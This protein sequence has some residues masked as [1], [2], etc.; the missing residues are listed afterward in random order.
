M[1]AGKSYIGCIEGNATPSKYVP[2]MIRWYREGK[3]PL[4]KMVKF[5]SA[6]DFKKGIQD[7]HHGADAV[8]PVIVW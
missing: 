7:M 6:E 2:Q 1:V 8:K 4:E 3:F 5:Y